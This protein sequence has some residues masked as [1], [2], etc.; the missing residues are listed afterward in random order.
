MSYQSKSTYVEF[1]SSLCKSQLNQPLLAL[2]ATNEGFG[3]TLVP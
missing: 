2:D 3:A 1:F